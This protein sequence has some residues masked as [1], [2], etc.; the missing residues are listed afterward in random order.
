MSAEGE[1]PPLRA[2][3]Q[4]NPKRDAAL[5]RA[6]HRMLRNLHPPPKP[7]DGVRLRHPIDWPGW[8]RIQVDVRFLDGG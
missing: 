1:T 5:T 2:R 6:F 4:K 3:R 7:V 8:V